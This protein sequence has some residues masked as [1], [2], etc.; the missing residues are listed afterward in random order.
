MFASQ[1]HIPYMPPAQHQNT[2]SLLRLRENRLA[3]A[4]TRQVCHLSLS[5]VVVGQV[6]SCERLPSLDRLAV[7]IRE[8][9]ARDQNARS[10]P[11]VERKQYLIQSYTTL[12][13]CRSSSRVFAIPTGLRGSN[14][15]RHS[16]IERLAAEPVLLANSDDPANP[17]KGLMRKDPHTR[18]GNN[19]TITQQA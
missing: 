8:N 12:S 13:D 14:I 6:R 5:V 15:R 18:I 4:T 1:H 11:R 16:F 2:T 19:T 3:A 7:K 10:L 17:P 9:G